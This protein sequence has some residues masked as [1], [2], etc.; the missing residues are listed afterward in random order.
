MSLSRVNLRASWWWPRR[1]DRKEVVW[2]VGPRVFFEE[3]LPC[4]CRFNKV[5]DLSFAW[6]ATQ[7]GRKRSVDVLCRNLGRFQADSGER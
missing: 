4:H 7:S 2:C 1:L 6:E 3:R 5:P